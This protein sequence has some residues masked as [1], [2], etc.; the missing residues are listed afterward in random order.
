MVHRL[1]IRWGRD[2]LIDAPLAA[3][4]D[5][6]MSHTL[7]S[8]AHNDTEK[9][10]VYG[11]NTYSDMKKCG[12]HQCF[13]VTKIWHIPHTV[14]MYGT[15]VVIYM[16][17]PVSARRCIPCICIYMYVSYERYG[18]TEMIDSVDLGLGSRY[19]GTPSLGRTVE[20]KL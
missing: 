10:S 18:S 4:C 3:I 1:G 8:K 5:N 17:V 19:G 16:R 6:E 7:T 15:G 9:V 12:A 20:Q 11:L 14:L 2:G 13:H